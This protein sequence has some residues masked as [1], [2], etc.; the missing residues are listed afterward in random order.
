MSY[1]N[2]AFGLEAADLEQIRE[3]LKDH[4][5]VDR[6][7]IFGSRAK[8]TYKKGSDVDIALF[9]NDLERTVTSISSKLNEETLLPYKFDVVDYNA[10]TSIDLKEHINRVGVVFYKKS[11]YPKKT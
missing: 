5:E 3:I 2:S 10:I 8:Q 9:G 7:V 4:P 1:K 11:L 6:G